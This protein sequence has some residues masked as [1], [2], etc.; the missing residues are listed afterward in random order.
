M[1]SFQ[2]GKLILRGVTGN[3]VVVSYDWTGQKP[4]ELGRFANSLKAAARAEAAANYTAIVFDTDYKIPIYY[5]Q[6]A[7]GQAFVST[8]TSPEELG[9]YLFSGGF[10]TPPPSQAK[11]FE[12]AISKGYCY[13]SADDINKWGNKITERIDQLFGG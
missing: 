8:V 12:F 13:D 5:N 7:I 9:K 3:F 2:F 4:Q 11:I 10:L 1:D 6:G